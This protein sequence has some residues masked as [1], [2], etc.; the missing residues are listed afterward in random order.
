MYKL[1]ISF[2]ALLI[3][4]CAAFFSVKGIATLFSGAFTSAVVM[5]SSLELGKLIATT[6]LHRYWSRSSFLLKAYLL[7]AVLVLMCITSMGTYGFLSSAY[8]SNASAFESIEMQAAT[9]VQQKQS[10]DTQVENY[11]ERIVTLNESRKQQ[12]KNLST[13]TSNSTTKY[14]LVYQDI[15]RANKEIVELQSKIDLT[16]QQILEKDTAISNLKETM[17]VASD[18]GT[19]K[20]IAENFNLPLN[21]VVKWFILLIVAVFDPLAVAL[22]L[23]WS[24]LI[25]PTTSKHTKKRDEDEVSS[26]YD[27]Y[28]VIGLQDNEDSKKKI[29]QNNLTSKQPELDVELPEQPVILFTEEEESIDTKETVQLHRS[30]TLKF[31][32]IR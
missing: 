4:G 2:T 13:V 10:L 16:R 14:K 21:V 23:A 15:E 7:I 31:R 32:S 26:E 17:L 9:I 24:T 30:D 28:G 22:V 5:A 6:F 29:T 20:F 27:E 25:T 8:Q 1:L 3:A 11:Q 19:F 12:E 18:I